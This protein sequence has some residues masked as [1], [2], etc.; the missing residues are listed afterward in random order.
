M[1]FPFLYFYMLKLKKHRNPIRYA[2]KEALRMSFWK[3]KPLSNGKK[4]NLTNF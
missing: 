4:N 1:L 2:H 3:I